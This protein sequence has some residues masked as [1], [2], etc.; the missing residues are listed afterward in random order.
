MGLV[1]AKLDTRVTEDITQVFR[2]MVIKGWADYTEK[3]E[4]GSVGMESA[5]ALVD[6][7]ELWT[8]R[9]QAIDSGDLKVY[10]I[11]ALKKDP[12]LGMTH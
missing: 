11:H 9:I 5:P 8:R 7:V 12:G 4:P 3:A 10:R 1:S 6:E 2:A